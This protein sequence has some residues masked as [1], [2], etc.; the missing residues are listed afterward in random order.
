MQ[1][2][3]QTDP[4]QTVELLAPALERLARRHRF[5]WQIV[6]DSQGLCEIPQIPGVTTRAILWTD[7]TEIE[8]LGRFDIGV[9]PLRDEPWTRFKCGC[10]LIQYM[11]IGA[12][13]VASPV[14]VNSEIADSG[15]AA[16]LAETSQDWETQLERL[17]V[18]STTRR[19][20][21]VIARQRVAE[22]YC[23]QAVFPA[24]L[25]AVLGE[26]DSVQK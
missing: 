9:M 15:R 25:K 22:R 11:A 12:A 21:A 18:S 8:A 17:L 26:L 6:T 3:G 1:L 7:S 23:L 2:V 5:E 10:K 13:A 4:N 16:L 24:W 14:G 20:L 19:E